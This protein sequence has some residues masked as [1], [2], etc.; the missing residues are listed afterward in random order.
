MTETIAIDQVSTVLA[1]P[2]EVPDGAQPGDA[3]LMRRYAAGEAAAFD[4]LYGRYRNKLYRYLVHQCRDRT[5]ADD[6]FQEVW[7]RVIRSAER[8]QPTAKFSTWL[9]HI[10]HNCLIDHYRQ[11]G[12]RATH[13]QSIDAHAD[14]LVDSQPQPEQQASDAQLGLALRRA[15]Q[16]LPAE[17][18]EAFVLHEEGG[19]SLDEVA[20]VTATGVETAKSRLRYAVNK[21]RTALK[22][23]RH[24]L[25]ASS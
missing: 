18:R 17:Q 20:Q 16:A 7:D 2:G 19:L 10:A 1:P 12:R 22:G 3:V 5:T 13:L 25:E 4:M 24:E 11:S 9:F 23:L 15:L 8:Y 14:E 6:V 21:L